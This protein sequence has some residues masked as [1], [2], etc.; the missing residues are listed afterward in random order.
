MHNDTTSSTI[1]RADAAVDLMRQENALLRDER[2]T[3]AN[4][5]ALM[6]EKIQQ[7]QAS[8]KALK[9]QLQTLA[10]DK[11]SEIAILKDETNGVLKTAIEKIK[12]IKET[13]YTNAGMGWGF[14]YDD[15]R[16]PAII[17]I[18]AIAILNALQKPNQAMTENKT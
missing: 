9:A 1:T 13:S 16:D 14:E 11:G 5:M 10:L 18:E 3:F 7:L 2:D 12:L 17:K 15:P 4:E 8:E 6:A